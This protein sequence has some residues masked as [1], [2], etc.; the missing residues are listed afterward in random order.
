M[1]LIE[2]IRQLS[3]TAVLNQPHNS[4]I[5]RVYVR[6]HLQQIVF[7]ISLHNTDEIYNNVTNN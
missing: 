4:E 6:I 5:M 1:I 3:G 2:F 7:N